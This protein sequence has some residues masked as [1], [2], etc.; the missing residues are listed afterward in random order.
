MTDNFYPMLGGMI[1]FIERLALSLKNRGHLV[2]IMAPS[3]QFFKKTYY[4][5]GIKV[6][7]LPSI[8]T[9]VYKN[10]YITYP[11]FMNKLIRE[12]IV[13]FNPD[14]IHIQSHFIVAKP[15]LRVAR[16]MSI[17]TIGTIHFM[18]E[19]M[20]P[21]LHFPNFAESKVRKQIWKKL[22][23]VYEQFDLTTV[24]TKTAA[25]CVINNGFSKNALVISNGIDLKEFNP[26][27]KGDYLRKRY[28]IPAN[29]II[30]Y[31][32]RLDKEKNL[33]KILIALSYVLKKID[34]HF[35]IAGG[36]GSQAKYLKY[37]AKSLRLDKFVTFTGYV[38]SKNLPNLYSVAN[39]FVIA[40]SA[41]LQSIATMEAMASG[42]P[43]IAA[44]CMAL[45]ELVKHNVNGF[46]FEPSD[47]TS[48]AD[49]IF[50]I[51]SNEKLQKEMSAKSMEIIKK[52]D[53]KK[54]IDKY[55]SLYQS[56]IKTGSNNNGICYK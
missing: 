56:L 55:E 45:P 13:E 36:V 42:K 3:K 52:H 4:H 53:I 25:D 54:I 38:S 15:V 17:P 44:N 37:L 43:V 6:F 41:E 34:I 12:A 8:P 19:N 31:V 16:E 18:P 40:S 10:M 14:V 9:W 7:G 27:N 24:P 20:M 11:F 1:V 46:L 29:P 47:T 26:K 30:L 51:I 28:G 21:H 48:L 32:G 22:F 33:D 2:L 23:K 5:K 49:Y 50:N 39:C 35:V